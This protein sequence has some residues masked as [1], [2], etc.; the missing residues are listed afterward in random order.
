MANQQPDFAV[1]AQAVHQFG[2]QVALM[3]NTA[4]SGLAAVLQEIQ[5]MN[6]RFDRF[7]H[8][9]KAEYRPITIDSRTCTY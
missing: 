3:G 1:A 9:L 8:S 6:Q 2:N 4:I 7:E 5:Q